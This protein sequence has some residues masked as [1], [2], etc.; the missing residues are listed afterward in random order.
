MEEEELKLDKRYLR[1][2]DGEWRVYH[3]KLRLD[4]CGLWIVNE[5]LR[6]PS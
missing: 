3:L 1:Q 2:E 6:I 5:D 4:G